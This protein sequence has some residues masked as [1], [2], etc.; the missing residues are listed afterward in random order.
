MINN[1]YYGVYFNDETLMSMETESKK[2]YFI[3]NPSAKQE[4]LDSYTSET[5]PKERDFQKKYMLLERFIVHL[6]DEVAKMPQ[7]FLSLYIRKRLNFTKTT[8]LYTLSNGSKL[9][10]QSCLD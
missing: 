6:N 2:I 7:V 9:A 4:K 3:E 1:Q 5:L 10:M 8:L